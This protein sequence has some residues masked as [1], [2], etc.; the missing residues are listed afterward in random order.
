MDI[1]FKYASNISVVWEMKIF[2][3]FFPIDSYVKL[4]PVVVAILYF[5]CTKNVNF[6]KDYSMIIH[7]QFRFNQVNSF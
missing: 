4:C 1:P 2:I 6:E 3:T 5:R 7:M